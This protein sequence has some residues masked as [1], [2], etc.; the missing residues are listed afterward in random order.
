MHSYRFLFG[1]EEVLN[2]FQYQSFDANEE[3]KKG[4]APG[5]LHHNEK[6]INRPLTD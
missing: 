5:D 3:R 6:A 1:E 2:Y 4:H